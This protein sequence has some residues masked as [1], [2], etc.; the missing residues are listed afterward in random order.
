MW[1]P[2]DRLDGGPPHLIWRTL[3]RPRAAA[4]RARRR[5]AI[6]QI[7]LRL[8]PAVLAIMP[9]SRSPSYRLLITPSNLRIPRAELRSRI[10]KEGEASDRGTSPHVC[11]TFPLGRSLLL[12]TC[13]CA[14]RTETERYKALDT[15]SVRL[16]NQG[17]RL[18]CAA[19]RPTI[20]IST[21]L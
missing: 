5:R 11:T 21:I 3:A 12:P 4:P 14:L 19:P 6:K 15:F 8:L 1:Y 10:R 7:P 18:E 20:S 9:P 16:L 2:R 13:Y 17:P